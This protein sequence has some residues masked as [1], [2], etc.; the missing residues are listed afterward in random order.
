MT[1]QE[2]RL[3]YPQWAHLE[4]DALWDAMEDLATSPVILGPDTEWITEKRGDNTYTYP[5]GC[6]DMFETT[7]D[8]FPKDRV[9]H[10]MFVPAGINKS[11][12]M[13]PYMDEFMGSIGREGALKRE[14]FIK[15][16]L[17]KAGYAHLCDYTERRFPKVAIVQDGLWEY[18]YVDDDTMGGKFIVAMEKWQYVNSQ[19]PDTHCMKMEFRFHH[20]PPINKI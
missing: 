19:T 8:L 3:K 12:S 17:K 18:V 2:F 16:E 5:K 10:A 7:K 14:N 4:G 13:T 1:T 9:N 15:E 6:F 11:M 20:T